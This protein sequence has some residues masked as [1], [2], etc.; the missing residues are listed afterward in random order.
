MKI[1]II[2]FFHRHAFRYHAVLLRERF[3]ANKDVKDMRVARKLVE[4][5]EA[6]LFHKAHPQPIG[7]K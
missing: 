6:E 1:L 7:C 3:D 4:D 5:G 2:F